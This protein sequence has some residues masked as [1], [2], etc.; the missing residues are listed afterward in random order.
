[1]Q[2][3]CPKLIADWLY[4]LVEFKEKEALAIEAKEVESQLLP[5]SKK[6]RQEVKLLRQ[7]VRFLTGVLVVTIT[8]FGSSFIWVARSLELTPWE[9]LPLSKR[10]FSIHKINNY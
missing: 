5:E 4:S 6:S 1:M 2:P 3:K 8:L 7:K 9:I 10:Q